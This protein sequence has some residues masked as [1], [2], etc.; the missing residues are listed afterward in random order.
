MSLLTC[1]VMLIPWP[2]DTSTLRLERMLQG[3]W[4]L[5]QVKQMGEV[6]AQ[7]PDAADIYLERL[8]GPIELREAPVDRYEDA[9]TVTFARPRFVTRQSGLVVAKGDYAIDRRASPFVL[10]TR[11]V[12]Y[13]YHFHEHSRSVFP[14]ERRLVRARVSIC[15]GQLCLCVNATSG[16]LPDGFRAATDDV[17][18]VTF[19]RF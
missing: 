5:H 18:L 11:G 19:S 3:T 1:T 14:R 8:R 12:S 9:V 4:V 16:E 15:S 13:S 17:Y 7:I 10:E 2:G 6:T